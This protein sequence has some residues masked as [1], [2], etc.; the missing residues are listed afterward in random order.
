M[1]RKG[2]LREKNVRPQILT[3]RVSHFSPVQP[4]KC[5][6]RVVAR[7]SPYSAVTFLACTRWTLPL[8]RTT[9]PACWP[10]LTSSHC[11]HPVAACTR[12][13]AC[14]SAR[15]HLLSC[16]SVLPFTPL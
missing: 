16:I 14:S 8:T 15:S 12:A 2:P 7:L 6:I 5:P 11:A 3:F 4:E 9:L 1:D 10:V 13:S